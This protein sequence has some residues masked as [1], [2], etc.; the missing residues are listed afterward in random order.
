MSTK[1][2][3]IVLLISMGFLAC[4]KESTPQPKTT[5]EKLLGKWN[6]ISTVSNHF[7]SGSSHIMTVTGA[8]GDYAD[9]RN[10]GKVYSLTNGSRD[11]AAY[12]IVNDS[13]IWIDNT[14]TTFDLKVFTET[15][16]QLY[17][18]EILNA[19]DYDEATVT[20]KK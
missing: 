9:F 8:A 7:Y 12:G 14:S 20:L 18:K 2:L 17:H 3:G 16:L 5:Q 6:Y 11:T 1:I 13:K 10:D 4:K 15:D 19:T